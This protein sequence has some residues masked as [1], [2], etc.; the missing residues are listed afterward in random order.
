MEDDNTLIQPMFTCAE[1]SKLFRLHLK[2][3]QDKCLSGE[4]P[5]I[6]FGGSNGHWRIPRSFVTAVLSGEQ[7]VIGEHRK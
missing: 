7:A 4:I 2:S 6:R 1:V 3:V 5:A